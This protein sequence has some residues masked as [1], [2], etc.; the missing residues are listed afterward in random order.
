MASKK[1]NN[2]NKK[3]NGEEAN[4]TVALRFPAVIKQLVALEAAR[5]GM[6][7]SALVELAI[8]RY[9][10]VPKRRAA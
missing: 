7:K 4:I 8:R 10:R 3:R 6:G 9:L 2:S 1:N 5:R